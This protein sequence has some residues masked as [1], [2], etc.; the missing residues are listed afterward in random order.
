M[1]PWLADWV[2]TG[3]VRPDLRCEGRMPVQSL[4]T[5]RV[6]RIPGAVVMPPILL[7]A[8]T[9]SVVHERATD[10]PGIWKMSG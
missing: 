10:A 3:D 5:P 7:N 9:G 2:A 1:A 6:T 8:P 4:V